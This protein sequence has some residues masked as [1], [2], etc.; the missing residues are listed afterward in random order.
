MAETVEKYVRRSNG[1]ILK[2]SQRPPFRIEKTGEIRFNSDAAFVLEFTIDNYHGITFTFADKEIYCESQSGGMPYHLPEKDCISILPPASTVQK[3]GRFESRR[4]CMYN[5]KWFLEGISL[6][7]MSN[8]TSVI[9]HWIWR[10]I[11]LIPFTEKEVKQCQALRERANDYIR[12]L[13]PY[14]K[15]EIVNEL[16]THEP[17]LSFLKLHE[18][19]LKAISEFEDIRGVMNSIDIRNYCMRENILEEIGSMT[20]DV[21]KKFSKEHDHRVAHLTPYAE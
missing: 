9:T 16:K 12:H 10:C 15:P 20:E 3:S 1:S 5:I 2:S 11:R 7:E 18:D 6:S 17:T 14:G 13:E 8:I 19:L 21:W 4:G